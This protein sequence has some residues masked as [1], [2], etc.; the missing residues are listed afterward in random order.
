MPSLFRS[1]EL[2]EENLNIESLNNYGSLYEA[3]E[4]LGN[5]LIALV[6]QGSYDPDSVNENASQ[7]IALTTG[8]LQASTVPER[9][10]R[11]GQY[12]ASVAVL[13]QQMESLARLRQIREGLKSVANKPAN[14][15]LL[16]M[17]LRTSYGRLSELAHVSNG[18]LLQDLVAAE[19]SGEVTSVVPTFRL[20]WLTGILSQHVFQLVVLAQE[21]SL[22]HQELY[23]SHDLLDL[24]QYLSQV[25]TVLG[26]S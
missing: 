9:L 16:P 2:A 24:E 11:S 5:L 12:W 26:G 15:S 18:E 10:V 4:L 14:V 6:N 3:Y 13:R 1:I 25:A 23:P 7:R 21:I 19:G 22:L 8:L 20:D 17:A